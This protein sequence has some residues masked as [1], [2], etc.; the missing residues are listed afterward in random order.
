MLVEGVLLAMGREQ[1]QIKLQ[2]GTDDPREN[3]PT[4]Q[5][6]LRQLSDSFR[7][8]GVE[9]TQRARAF[10][11]VGAVGYTLAEFAVKTIA[12]SA[13]SAASAVLV[14]WVQARN[15]RKVRVKIGDV[16]AE[17]RSVAEIE[18]LLKRAAAF[19]DQKREQSETK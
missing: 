10:D 9:F 7:A 8:T 14:M 16:E 18:D 13:I 6:E 4:F 2:R 11:A 5:A 17:G 3:D 19:Q 15:G 1:I 12:P